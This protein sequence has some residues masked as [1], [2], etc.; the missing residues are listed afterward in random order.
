MPRRLNYVI[1]ETSAGSHSFI[2]QRHDLRGDFTFSSLN[3]Q[4]TRVQGWEARPCT[5][6]LV[7]EH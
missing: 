7:L 3:P 5:I 2:V 1:Q 4:C 6:A